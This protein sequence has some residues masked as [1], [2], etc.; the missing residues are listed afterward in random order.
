M[1]LANTLFIDRPPPPWVRGTAVLRDPLLMPSKPQQQH[2]LL[3]HITTIWEVRTAEAFQFDV[4]KNLNA[5]ALKQTQLPDGDAKKRVVPALT[6]II[7][8]SPAELHLPGT[9]ATADRPEDRVGQVSA[10]QVCARQIASNEPRAPKRCSS[11]VR[12]PEITECEPPPV[13]SCLAQISFR[14][15]AALQEQDAW[16]GHGN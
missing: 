10:P 11:E 1:P 5:D 7:E 9:F 15:Y 8:E 16:P 4:Q 2:P 13:E 14:E 3:R 6:R 12:T